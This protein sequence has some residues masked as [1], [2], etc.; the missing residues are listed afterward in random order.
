MKIRGPFIWRL[1][2]PFLRL[3]GT[4]CQ[5]CGGRHFPGRTVCPECSQKRKEQGEEQNYGLR[6]KEREG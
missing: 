4:N 1:R 3:E 6:G 2:G 5:E